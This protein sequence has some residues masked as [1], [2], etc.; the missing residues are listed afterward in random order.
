MDWC[1]KDAAKENDGDRFVILWRF[2]FLRYAMT[3]HIKYRLLAF[4]LQV[5]LMALLPPKLAHELKNNRCVNI[6]G[7]TRALEFMN[8]RAK[9]ALFGLHDNLTPAVI[10]RCGRRLQ[11]CNTIVDGYTKGLEQFL[12][13]LPTRRR[14]YKRTYIC[15]SKY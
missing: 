12:G 10:Q 9:D 6:H 14:H 5:Q 8:M 2:D 13:N 11:G 3:N 1:R 4:K 15:L 7:G